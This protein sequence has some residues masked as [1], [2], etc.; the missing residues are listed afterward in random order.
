MSSEFYTAN[1]YKMKNNSELSESM[2]DYLEMIMRSGEETVRVSDL[3]RSLNIRASSVTKMAIRLKERGMIKYQRYGTINLT[4]KGKQMAEFLIY[5]HDVLMNFF[6][7][8]NGTNDVLEEVEGIEHY[9]KSN[10]VENLSKLT[11]IIKNKKRT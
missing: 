1:G 10:T 9:L 4:E 7:T 8:L 2:E 6:S 5:R 3:A 11:K